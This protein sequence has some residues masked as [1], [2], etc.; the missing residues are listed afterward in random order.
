MEKFLEYLSDEDK[1]IY[2]KWS[3][4]GLLSNDGNIL[5]NVFLAKLYE[6]FTN[7]ML[8]LSDNPPKWWGDCN[9]AVIFI[10]ITRKLCDEN[11]TDNHEL[12][13]SKFEEWFGLYGGNYTTD[14]EYVT[15]FVNYFREFIKVN[16][17]DEVKKYAVMSE[18]TGGIA[19]PEYK[20]DV[21]IKNLDFENRSKVEKEIIL[22]ELSD[23]LKNDNLNICYF[24]IY[25]IDSEVYSIIETDDD[26]NIIN[27][28]LDGGEVIS[29]FS[30]KLDEISGK[31][32]YRYNVN[33]KTS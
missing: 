33:N 31:V 16:I 24:P 19:K 1:V 2:E 22:G 13:Y 23:L 15:E 29:I 4:L 32:V 27:N 3:E 20:V 10:P 7:Y 17:S 12:I 8:G 6:K 14:I 25:K 28:H 21:L 26:I 11:L 30:G 9:F 18:E 5:S